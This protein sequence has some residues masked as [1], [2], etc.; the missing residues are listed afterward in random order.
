MASKDESKD[1]RQDFESSQPSEH[2][3]SEEAAPSTGEESHVDELHLDQ[4]GVHADAQ[5]T[6]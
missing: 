2:Q 4:D 3:H 1:P 5:V 6:G